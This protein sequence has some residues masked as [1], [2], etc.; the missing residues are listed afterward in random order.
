MPSEKKK[1]QLWFADAA[2]HFF[3]NETETNLATQSNCLALN[4]PI[5]RKQRAMGLR[6]SALYPR[7]KTEISRFL[8]GIDCIKEQQGC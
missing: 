2:I 3:E 6:E 4:I 5:G 1:S 8:Q 7:S